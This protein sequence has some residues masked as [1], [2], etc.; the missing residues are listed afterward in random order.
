MQSVNATVPSCRLESEGVTFQEI[1]N[2][3][4]ESLAPHY[5]N[6]SRVTMTDIGFLLGYD[7]PSSFY[8]AFHAWTGV[9][10]ERV[11]LST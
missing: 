5:L 2:E 7:E 6:K 8:R 10:P 4:R 11:R 3:T 1:L 9:T